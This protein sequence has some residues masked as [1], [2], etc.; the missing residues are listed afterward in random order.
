MF[1]YTKFMKYVHHSFQSGKKSKQPM[2]QDWKITQRDGK[3]S[4]DNEN[5]WNINKGK[6]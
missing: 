5:R 3:E 2:P 4:S 1:Q 6:I